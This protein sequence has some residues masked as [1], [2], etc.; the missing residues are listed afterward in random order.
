MHIYRK[1]L[2]K[3]KATE[4]KATGVHKTGR[5]CYNLSGSVLCEKRLLQWAY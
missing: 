4:S 2:Q 3:R 1:I 5:L